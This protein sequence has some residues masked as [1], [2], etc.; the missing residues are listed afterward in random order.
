MTEE[1]RLNRMFSLITQLK[2]LSA[3]RYRDGTVGLLKECSTVEEFEAVEHVLKDL[4][5]CNSSDL[6][7]AAASA[8]KQIQNGWGLTPENTILVGLA[9]P[10]KTCGSTAYLRAIENKLPR[11]WGNSLHVTFNAAF[12]HRNNKQNLVLVDDFIGTGDKLNKRIERLINNP[13]TASYE[14]HIAAFAGMIDGIATL[15]PST[16]NRATA[17]ILLD[18]SISNNAPAGNID[19]LTRNMQ[20][21]ETKIFCHPGKYNFGYGQSEAAF[22]VEA[23]NIPNNNFPILWWEKYADDTERPTLFTRR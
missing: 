6:D 8:A 1:E 4:K 17:E 14:I 18:K 23:A 16:K 15:L 11:T 13:K 3:E 21:L 19:R 12:R 20:S 9:E 10:D 5:Y 7:A 2:W 22:F